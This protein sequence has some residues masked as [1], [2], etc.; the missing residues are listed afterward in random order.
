MLVI[1][2]FVLLPSFHS[3][4]AINVFQTLGCPLF[5]ELFVPYP[6]QGSDTFGYTCFVFLVSSYGFVWN[7]LLH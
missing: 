4:V 5:L 3:L 1:P 7:L 2:L 6:V